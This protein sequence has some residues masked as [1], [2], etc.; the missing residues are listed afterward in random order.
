MSSINQMLTRIPKCTVGIC[1]GFLVQTIDKKK[2][3][4]HINSTNKVG[5]NRISMFLQTLLVLIMMIQ[6]GKQICLQIQLFSSHAKFLHHFNKRFLYHFFYCLH[7][8]AILWLT[9]S[10]PRHA[11]LRKAHH[12]IIVYYWSGCHRSKCL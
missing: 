3:L 7:K 10:M 2:I 5:L 4:L 11:P 8:N 1:L 9:H 12:N 6:L